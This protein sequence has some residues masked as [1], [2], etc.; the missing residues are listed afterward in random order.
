MP[1]YIIAIR[2]STSDAEALKAYSAA[3][4]GARRPNMKVLAAYGASETLEGA[5]IEGVVLIEFP[6]REAAKEWYESP[7]YQ[8]ARELRL[9]AADYQFILFDGL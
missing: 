4:G 7:A 6:T 8:Q 1:S 2:N 5:P 3:A 9:G